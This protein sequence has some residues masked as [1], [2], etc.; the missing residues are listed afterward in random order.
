[1]HY[2]VNEKEGYVISVQ[3]G[4][5]GC[6]ISEEHYND[7]MTAIQNRPIPPDGYGYRLKTDLTWEMYEL[8]VSNE[9]EEIT[10]SEALAIITGGES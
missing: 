7:I 10:D 9:P 6:E 4:G 1:M 8:P 2:F 3:R 5:V